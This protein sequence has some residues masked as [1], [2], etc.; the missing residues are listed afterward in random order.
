MSNCVSDTLR[1]PRLGRVVIGKQSLTCGGGGLNPGR[2]SRLSLSRRVR[3]QPLCHATADKRSGRSRTR[4]TRAEDPRVFS[5]ALIRRLFSPSRPSAARQPTEEVL[6]DALGVG[7]I[8]SRTTARP[9]SVM[10]ANTAP[11]VRAG[12]AP[13][14]SGRLQPPDLARHPT[15]QRHQLLARSPSW[16]HR[17]RRCRGFRATA[18]TRLSLCSSTTFDSKVPYRPIT[19]HPEI[20][21]DFLPAMSGQHLTRGPSPIVP[22][23]TQ[24]YGKPG[25]EVR[26]GA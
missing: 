2:F 7:S 6:A 19:P 12:V 25:L 9:R 4:P 5:A 14:Q 10:L 17:S 13:Y 23:I 20:C 11:V 1:S 24:S 8:A 16:P 21:Q 15:R 18:S 26:I 22:P 3:P